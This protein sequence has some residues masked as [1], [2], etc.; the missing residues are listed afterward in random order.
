MLATPTSAF[1]ISKVS[2]LWQLHMLWG[3]WWSISIGPHVLWYMASSV[4]DQHGNCHQP[5]LRKDVGIQKNPGGDGRQNL[6]SVRSTFFVAPTRIIG[7][8]WWRNQLFPT[9]TICGSGN[10]FRKNE[11]GAALGAD[12]GITRE[13][14]NDSSRRTTADRIAWRRSRT[15]ARGPLSELRRQSDHNIVLYISR[16]D[17]I[18]NKSSRRGIYILISNVCII[19]TC[20]KYLTKIA[21]LKLVHF[22]F[23]RDDDTQTRPASSCQASETVQNRPVIDFCKN[24]LKPVQKMPRIEICRPISRYDQKIQKKLDFTKNTNGNPIQFFV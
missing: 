15:H 10:H 17:Q 19:S 4:P 14:A 13:R 7:D 16:V 21:E 23:R 3:W 11:E 22:L 8:R 12:V 5:P 1:A 6:Q 20:I 24:I 9:N 2:L 18:I